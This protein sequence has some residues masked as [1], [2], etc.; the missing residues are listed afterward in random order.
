MRRHPALLLGLTLAFSLSAIPARA[1]L[2]LSELCDPASNYTTDR[3][4]E[5]YNSGPGAVDLTGWAVVAIANDVDECTWSLSGSLPA[6]QARVMGYTAPVTAFTVNF[7]LASWN[8]FGSGGDAYNWNGKINDG[9][10]LLNPSAVIVDYIKAPATLFENSTIVRTPG[11]TDPNPVY[12]ASEWTVTPVTLAT[13]ASPGSHNGSTAVAGPVISNV[14]TAPPTPD[15]DQVVDVYAAVVDTSGAIASVTLSWGTVSNSLTNDIAMALVA[16][17]TYGTVSQI[18][19]QP[20]G[21]TVYYRIAAVGA[22]ATTTTSIYSYTLPGGGTGAPTILAVGEMSDSTLLV[23]F[24]EPVEETSAETPGHYAVGA[25][26]VVAA[27]RD[28]AAPANVLITVRGLT[29]GTRTVT[30]NGVADLEANVAYGITCDFHYV[31][32]SIPAGYYDSAVGLTGWALR[33]ALHAIIDGHTVRSYDYA[34][35]A[36]ATTDIKWNGKIWDVYSDVPG[37]VPPY[38]YEYGETG[39]GATEGLGYNR[40]HVMPQSW[41]NGVSPPY[42]DLFNLYPTDSYVN[43]R[44]ANYPFGEVGTASWTSLNGSKLGTSV[45]EGYGGT[46]FEPIDAFKGDLVRSHFY[47]STRYYG[48]DASWASSGATDGA[49]LLP[50]AA[51]QYLA[52][53]DTDPVSWKE[54]MRNGAVYAIQGNRNPFV[55]HPEFVRAIYDSN[56]VVGVGDG[57]LAATVRLAPNRPNPF[58]SRTSL[59]FD[60]PRPGPIVLRV[61]DVSGRGVRTLADGEFAAGSHTLDWDGRDDGGAPLEAGLYFCRLDAGA[62]HATRRLVRTR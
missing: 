3:F 27:V 12:T 33:L 51:A 24:S 45:S 4:I 15:A 57:A 44:R 19:G 38:E 22:Q 26:A 11:V 56:S 6:G 37:G 29:A 14:V 42:S 58:S 62:A 53:S 59:R 8:A 39:Q 23:Q 5:I 46:V 52:W 34:L 36:F 31:D 55:D 1:G 2:F 25:L 10:K 20:G 17:S 41:F 40:E 61:Y 7:P 18:P 32:V 16:D 43:N 50:W 9:A 60:L 35:T 28:D 54:R 49:E 21:A 30:V 13:D 47:M 48:E